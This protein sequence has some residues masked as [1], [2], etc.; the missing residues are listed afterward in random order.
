MLKIIW[1]PKEKIEVS[2]AEIASSLAGENSDVQA[3]FLNYL[4]DYL[5]NGCKGEGGFQLQL[6]HLADDLKD[7]NEH[8]VKFILD[9]A[10]FLESEN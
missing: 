3:K 7:K 4:G 9:L 1:D 10:A 6:A 2:M 8:G 5:F